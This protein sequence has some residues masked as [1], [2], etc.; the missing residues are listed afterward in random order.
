MPKTYLAHDH[1]FFC[2]TFF[3]PSSF[4]LSPTLFS[5]R[6]ASYFFSQHIQPC[7]T[8]LFYSSIFT[9]PVALLL[10]HHPSSV[11]FFGWRIRFCLFCFALALII[12]T[13]HQHYQHII[14]SS[15][16]FFTLHLGARISPSFFNQH[17]LPSHTLAAA[18][19]QLKYFIFLLFSCKL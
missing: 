13:R 5:F 16:L 11:H 17:W 19:A 9:S 14:I 8:N 10:E 15:L 18:F 12:D 6:F 1:L 4:F 7:I 2:L 3:Q